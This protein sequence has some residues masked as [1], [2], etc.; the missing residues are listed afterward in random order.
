M[1]DDDRYDAKLIDRLTAT[2][3]RLRNLFYLNFVLAAAV[4]LLVLQD[5]AFVSE[6]IGPATATLQ[7]VVRLVERMK[8]NEALAYNYQLELQRALSVAEASGTTLREAF[9]RL[10]ARPPAERVPVYAELER[11]LTDGQRDLLDAFVRFDDYDPLRRRVQGYFELDLA[12]TDYQHL[13]EFGAF[14]IDADYVAATLDRGRALI[15]EIDAVLPLDVPRSQDLAG[16]DFSRLDLGH[17]L[18]T[19]LYDSAVEAEMRE[20]P[21]SRDFF[22]AVMIAHTFCQANG[23]EN[24]SLAGIRRW[25]DQRAAQASSRLS[26]PGLE[27]NVARELIVPASP[28]VFLVAFHIYAMQFR[29]RQVLRHRL[30]DHLSLVQM[31]LLD[32][33]WVLNSV[34]LNI[35]ASEGVWRRIQSALMTVFLVL[36]QTAPLIAVAVAGYFTF[37]QVLLGAF[38]ADEFT[39]TLAAVTETLATLGVENLPRLPAPPGLF[40]E[41]LWIAVAAFTALVLSIGLVQMLVDQFAE[42]RDAWRHH[43]EI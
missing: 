3:A 19:V 25:Q 42:I 7:P 9:A 5:P 40:W 12:T 17:F 35:A 37:K 23:L 30:R 27:V 31:N 16:R 2:T 41:Y 13:A 1:P 21:V 24:C 34:V 32:E 8:Q 43:G 39:T 28:V 36:A 10:D 15:L 26:T 11:R 38:I 14:L 4:V 22:R 29:R 18:Q 6:R 33:P 20:M